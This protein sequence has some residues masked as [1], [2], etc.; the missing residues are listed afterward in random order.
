M[1]LDEIHVLLC[2]VNSVS[3]LLHDPYRLIAS[4]KTSR[5]VLIIMSLSSKLSIKDLDLKGKVVA[6]QFCDHK[7]D[8]PF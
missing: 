5:L 2:F 1:C 8:D 6:G 7:S 4:D 3:A